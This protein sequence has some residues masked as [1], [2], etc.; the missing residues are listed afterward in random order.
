MDANAF[1]TWAECQEP[2]AEEEALIGQLDLPLNLRGNERHRYWG[3]LSLR[4]RELKLAAR[5]A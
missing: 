2:W 4:R 5:R 1:V 3:A